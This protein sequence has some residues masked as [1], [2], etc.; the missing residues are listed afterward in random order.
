M[1]A[2]KEIIAQIRKIEA[3]SPAE[4]F[5]VFC[6]NV[7]VNGASAEVRI[8]LAEAL[9]QWTFLLGT[10]A[11]LWERSGAKGAK[12]TSTE[13]RAVIARV[14]ILR[15]GLTS[16]SQPQAQHVG[17]EAD[18]GRG[19]AGDRGDVVDALELHGWRYYEMAL[20]WPA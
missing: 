15:T 13:L 2:D 19:V 16:A 20:E 9:G 8:A 7:T 17:V 11:D 6:D 14:N 5:G 18:V 10:Q 3:E 4:V 1:A 12:S